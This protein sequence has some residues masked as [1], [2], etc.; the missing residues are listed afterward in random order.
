MLWSMG[1]RRVGHNSAT[2]LPHT[3]LSAHLEPTSHLGGASASTHVTQEG[4]SSPDAWFEQGV[5]SALAFAKEA[6]VP[7]QHK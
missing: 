4:H 7:K 5:E 2:E 3:H 6:A 1:S